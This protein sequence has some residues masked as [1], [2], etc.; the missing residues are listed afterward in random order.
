MNASQLEECLPSM[1]QL[2]SVVPS[3]PALGRVDGRCRQEVGVQAHPRPHSE[4]EASL[5]YL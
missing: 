4:L 1:Q 2:L 5:E 3:E